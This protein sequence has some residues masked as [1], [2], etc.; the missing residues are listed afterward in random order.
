MNQHEAIE[1]VNRQRATLE[2]GRDME[3]SYTERAIVEHMKDRTRPGRVEDRI[4]WIV[5]LANNAGFVHVHVD[6]E[7]GDIL[8]VL[9]SA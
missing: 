5:E 3:V 6:D 9:R 2:I 8:E 1:I 7:T 4:A